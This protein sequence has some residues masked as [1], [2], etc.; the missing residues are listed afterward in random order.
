MP[1]LRLSATRSSL[2]S[3]KQQLALAQE[4]YRLLNK[5]RDVLVMEILR[6]IRDAELVQAQ[7]NEQ[8]Q[9]A[10]ASLQEARAAMGTERVRRV[11]LARAAAIKVD[12]QITPHSIMGVL[13]PDVRYSISGERL[14]Y[15]FGDTSLLLDEAQQ[16]W[17]K[18]LALLGHLAETV[19][20]V[21]RLALEL[22]RT[23][24]RV[25]ALDKVFIPTYQETF[26]YIES[27]LEEKD[28]E[29]LFRIKRA[30]ANLIERRL[31]EAAE[32]HAAG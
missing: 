28:R 32:K 21:W 10:Y 11:A 5:K 13:V 18:V 20:T 26:S 15:G 16:Q 6:M 14:L 4:G 23:Q 8:F 7:V 25:N 2:L 1:R 19:T 3:V 27:A 9:K 29:E 12:V 31:E 24:R 22:R 30:Q 17:A